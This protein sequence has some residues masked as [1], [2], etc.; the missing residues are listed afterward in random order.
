MTQHSLI[1]FRNDL[2]V[3]DSPALA[4]AIEAGRPIIPVYIHAPDEEGDWPA[5]AAS[6]WWLHHALVDL[7]EALDEAG[8]PLVIRRGGSLE[9]LRALA[10]EFDV[11][12]VYW[13]RRYEPA[14]VERDEEV[15]AALDKD[16]LEVRTSNAALLFEPGEVCNQSGE[17]YRVFTPFWKSLRSREPAA[18]VEV[19]VAAATAPEHS[20]E[21]LP[22]D[23]LGLLPDHGWDAGLAEAWDPSLQGAHR[24]LHDFIDGPVSDYKACRDRPG[25]RGTSRLSPYLHFGQL[26]PRQAWRAVLQAGRSDGQGGY[27]FLSELAWREFAHHLLHFFP[28][29][30]GQALNEAYRNFPWQRDEEYLRAWQ[31]GQTGFPMVD[32]GMRELWQTGWMHN[33]VRMLAASFLVKHLL[34]PWQ[35]GARWFWDTLVDADLANN[36]MGWQW[37]A[38][39]GA[40]AAPYF[41]IFNPILQGEKFDPKGRYVRR[42][43]P[44]LADLP[45][46][47]IHQP[48]EAPDEVLKEA[49]V[50]LGQDYPHPVIGHREGRERALEAL[51]E[52]KARNQQRESSS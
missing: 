2:R 3:Q 13:N 49:G 51:S 29:T 39:C 10:A 14:I 34:Q 22:P 5:G 38:G 35:D 24:V 46:K 4:A 48:W 23:A 8:L 9:T 26:G 45:D 21:S 28:D 33:R 40:D 31:R 52:N 37:T 27:T 41:R 11:S 7:A 18:P 42:Y 30:P 17:P 25:V 36:T 47:Y 19:D 6:R 1:W 44:E 12:T 20:P 50:K 43:V 16:G 15:A 32:A